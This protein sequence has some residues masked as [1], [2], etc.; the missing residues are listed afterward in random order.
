MTGQV[1][2]V[3]PK[4]HKYHA[5]RTEYAGVVYDSQGEAGYARHLEWHRQA[6]DTWVWYGW[7]VTFG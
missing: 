5:R 3:P 4:R 2:T 7:N 6:R 1:R